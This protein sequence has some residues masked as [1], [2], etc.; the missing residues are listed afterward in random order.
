MS[1]EVE[2]DRGV[3]GGGPLNSWKKDPQEALVTQKE[4]MVGQ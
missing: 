1:W 2:K 4:E 3:K